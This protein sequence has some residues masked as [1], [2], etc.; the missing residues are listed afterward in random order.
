MVIKPS[1]I[2]YDKMLPEDTVAVDVKSGKVVDG[3]WKPS[4]DTNIFLELYRAFTSIG[5]IA[6]THSTNAAA[7]AQAGMTIPA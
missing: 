4:S 6:H 3:K 2:A 5:G 7:F 1:G